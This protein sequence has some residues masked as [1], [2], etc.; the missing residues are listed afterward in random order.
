MQGT[1]WSDG[2]PGA[3]QLPIEPDEIFIYRFKASPSGTMLIQERPYWMD[4]MAESLSGAYFET[5]RPIPSLKFVW[6]ETQHA[7]PMEPNIQ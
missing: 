4:C 6:T 5:N 3:T 7:R 1:P 2:A